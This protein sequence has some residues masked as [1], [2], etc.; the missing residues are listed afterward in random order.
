MKT[1]PKGRYARREKESPSYFFLAA[2]GFVLAAGFFTVVFFIVHL[3]NRAETDAH[4]ESTLRAAPG[5]DNARAAVVH[6]AHQQGSGND[7]PSPL[8]HS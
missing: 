8:P 6:S 4:S 3:A 1:A 2:F 7:C 5:N